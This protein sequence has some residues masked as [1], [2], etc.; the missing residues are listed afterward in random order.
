MLTLAVAMA[1]LLAACSHP[2][3]ELRVG[4]SSWPGNAPFFLAADDGRLG[5]RVRMVEFASET[6]TLQAFR[7]RALDVAILTL[8]EAVL[9]ASEGHVVRIAALTDI[10]VGA[11]QI[12]ARPPLA[13]VKDLK[14]RRV[15]VESTGVGAFILAHALHQ[16]GMAVGDVD[17]V[18]LLP[19]E[20]PGE[21]EAGRIDAAVTH[22]PFAGRLRARGAQ[23]VFDTRQMDED[24]IRA[25]VVR[26]TCL[27]DHP[28]RLRDLV[29]ALHASRA[30]F[31]GEPALALAARRYGQTPAQFAQA[32]AGLRPLG[33][34]ENAAFF[35]AGARKLRGVLAHIQDE[36]LKAR[37]IGAPV[38]LAQ[39]PMQAAP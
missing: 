4:A 24:L 34:E 11:G 12:L 10:S 1:C 7:N 30:A 27:Q 14:G 18:V 26:D 37:L 5:E 8:D 31:S 36:M 21:Y 19:H 3:T 6:A 16:A 23:I 22:E 39:L 25:V 28:G 29:R 35:A 20:Q 32:Y 17:I 33:E 9:L 38:D 13:G 15:A 2:E